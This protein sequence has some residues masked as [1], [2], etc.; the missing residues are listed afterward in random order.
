[1]SSRTIGTDLVTALK[2][3]RLGGLLPTL[4]ERFT[5]AEKEDTPYEDLLLL[6]LADEISRR[7]DGH[8]DPGKFDGRGR[9]HHLVF[10]AEGD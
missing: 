5:L 8:D 3:L 6:L 4:A 7:V 2:R 9:G 1:M 10:L